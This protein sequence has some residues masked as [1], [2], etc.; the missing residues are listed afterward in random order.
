MSDIF[1]KYVPSGSVMRNL[2]GSQ[3][4]SSWVNYRLYV[5]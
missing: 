2:K 4:P 1:N 3:A 5:N